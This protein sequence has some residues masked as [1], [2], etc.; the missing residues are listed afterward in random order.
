MVQVGDIIPSY[1]FP[2]V[3][4]SEELE[5]HGA[6]GVPTT[7]NTDQW[8]GKLVVLVGVPGAFTPGCHVTH[9]PPYVARAK[10]LKAKGADAVV[11][12]AAN[13]LFVM[14]AWGRVVGAKNDVCFILFQPFSIQTDDTFYLS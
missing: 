10:E 3:P 1:K 8:K 9:I 11:F 6:C 7:L 12:V 13:D 2:Y 5:N 4:Y 14:S